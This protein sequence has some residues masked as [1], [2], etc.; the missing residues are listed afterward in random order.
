M[1]FDAIILA[2]GR[3]KRMKPFSDVISKPMLPLL[4]K[5]LVSIIAEQL[6]NIGAEKIV[7]TVSASNQEE[8]KNY[9]LRQPYANKI[10]FCLQ[11]PPRGTADAIYKAGLLCSSDIIYSMAGD[12]LFSLEFCK[13]MV[14]TYFDEKSNRTCIMALM[15]VTKEEITKLASVE[16]TETGKITSIKEKPK[17]EEVGSTLA[18]LSMYIFDKSLIDYFRNVQ[19]SPRGEYEAPDAFTAMM[20]DKQQV[21]L[22]GLV[23][24]ETY[25]HISNPYDL[26]KHNMDLL[27]DKTNEIG[28]NVSLGS[29]TII[30]HSV[31]GPNA[32]IEN[33]CLIEDSV[34]LENVRITSHLNIRKSI[35]CKKEKGFEEYKINEKDH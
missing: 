10:V 22:K 16:I 15:E 27:P 11:E 25:I 32:Q 30:L 13:K 9:F 23:T 33:N 2:A 24:R 3:G 26:W 19:L 14:T 17:I 5:P 31:I 6:F 34:I 28:D 35:L 21:N 1:K 20:H 29:E 12:N 7:I 18:S 8:I 4:N